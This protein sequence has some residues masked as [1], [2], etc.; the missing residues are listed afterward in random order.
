MKAWLA[1][2]VL[3]SVLLTGCGGGAR[4]ESTGEQ[5]APLLSPEAQIALDA[6]LVRIEYYEGLLAQMEEEVLKLKSEQYIERISYERRIAELMEQMGVQSPPSNPTQNGEALPF[7]YLKTEQGI[8]ILSYTGHASTVEIP[9]SIEGLPV[10]AIGDSAF[11]EQTQLQ[12]VVI[13][14]GVVSIGWFAFFGCVS[15]QHVAMPD[16]LIQISYGAFDYCAK[17]L[18]VL[19]SRDSYAAA[20][21]AM[22][23]ATFAGVTE[24]TLLMARMAP[25]P[26]FLTRSMTVC[27][28]SPTASLGSTTKTTASASPIAL[29]VY[30]TIKSPSFVRGL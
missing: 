20:Y 24:S 27:S 14:E 4:G 21:A 17:E 7:T 5:T 1:V 10:I 15:L 29:S 16:S 25:I 19:A 13:P 11:R 26:I 12:A 28:I 8:Q 23:L 9:A 6:A 22:V 18:T 30:F 2:I 3:L